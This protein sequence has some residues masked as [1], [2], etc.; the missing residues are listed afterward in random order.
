VNAANWRTIVLVA[1]A[2][3]LGTIVAGAGSLSAAW[4]PVARLIGLQ[5]ARVPSSANVFSEHEI[6]GLDGMKGNRQQTY[7][8]PIE[9]ADAWEVQQIIQS[10]YPSANNAGTSSTVTDALELRRTSLLNSMFA[11]GSASVSANGGSSAF[12]RGTS[13]ANR[14][15]G[16]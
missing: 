7:V 4:T 6:E 11:G 5:D 9:Y 12:S 8:I 13:S 14:A 16:Q 2:F 15:T 10:L 1:F 3:I